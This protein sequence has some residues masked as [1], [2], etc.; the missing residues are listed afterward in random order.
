MTSAGVNRTAPPTIRPSPVPTSA[1]FSVISARASAASFRSSVPDWSMRSE[2]SSVMPRM[3]NILPLCLLL[4]G[5]AFQEPRERE[6]GQHG[7]GEE[8]TGLLAGEITR[9]P[10]QL[11]D[12][13]LPQRAGGGIEAL[14][15]IVDEL[16]NLRHFASQA[17]G[18]SLHGLRGGAD[19]RR[20][21]FLLLL[22]NTLALPGGC[23]KRARTLLRGR[24]HLIPLPA[25][26]KVDL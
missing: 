1:I 14:R 23:I 8:H 12:L 25:T 16:G 20:P 18:G 10:D 9:L 7:P 13:L 6:P 24:G 11:V 3:M 26:I 19:P 15:H 17:I 22:R 5:R 2:K 4:A 21:C